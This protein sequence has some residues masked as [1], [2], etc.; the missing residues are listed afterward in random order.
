MSSNQRL[1]AKQLRYNKTQL[2]ELNAHI[3]ELL[4]DIDKVILDSHES[5]KFYI[6]HKLLS[7]FNVTNMKSAESR[8]RIH[9]NILSDLASRNFLVQY[10]KERENYYLKIKWVT[11]EEINKKENEMRILKFFQY[12][13]KD[14]TSYE[15]SPIVS[16]YGGINSLS[17]FFR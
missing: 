11:D 17:V 7:V 5:G 10:V 4:L 13:I 3:L 16:K 12:P 9:A 1:D 2:I 14:R 6:N 8:R 15:S